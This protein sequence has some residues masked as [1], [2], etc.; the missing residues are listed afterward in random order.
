MTAAWIA[1][2]EGGGSLIAFAS[3]DYELES[4]SG[5]QPCYVALPTYVYEAAGTAEGGPSPAPYVRNSS[6]ESALEL[7]GVV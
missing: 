6:T 5:T 2:G 4:T 3:T 1:L 7:L